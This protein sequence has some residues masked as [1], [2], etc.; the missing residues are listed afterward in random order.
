[1]IAELKSDWILSWKNIVTEQYVGDSHGYSCD[2]TAV[3]TTNGAGGRNVQLFMLS[4]DGVVLHVLPGFWHPDDLE[5]ELA[6]AKDLLA[7]WNDPALP[8]WAKRQAFMLEQQNH[9]A[10]HSD[11]TQARSRWQGF[12]AK[13][14]I[15]RF[16][17]L[18]FRDTLILDEHGQPLECKKGKPRLKTLDVL[19]H[20]RMAMRPFMRFEEFDTAVFADYGRRYYDNNKKVDGEG[21]TFMTP[22]R[23]AK[24]E[25]KAEKARLKAERARQREAKR[26]ARREA[27]QAAREA[28]K[29]QREAERRAREQAQ[30]AEG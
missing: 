18:G 12:D 22:D 19:M 8:D 16:E 26:Q 30:Q 20:D 10:D 28:K 25:R 15:K 5:T 23:V 21:E 6:F 27:Q 14:E 1:V 17:E 11:H 24:A 29:R 3:G 7:L 13:N 2:Q 4:P 9:A